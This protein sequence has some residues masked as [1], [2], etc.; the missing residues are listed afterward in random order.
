MQ[1]CYLLLSTKMWIWRQHTC[2]NNERSGR[3]SWWNKPC[4]LYTEF[5]ART[6][7]SLLKSVY[8]VREWI[9]AQ[10]LPLFFPGELMIR[11]LLANAVCPSECV[12]FYARNGVPCEQALRSA[13]VTGRERE[14][15]LATIRLWKKEETSLRHVA[16][17]H[18][19]EQKENRL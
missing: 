18:I 7:L 6:F 16:M 9:F 19:H 11:N 14:G 10:A 2:T 3:D 15:E 5:P 13:V 17:V 12:C 1:K 4:L 8:T